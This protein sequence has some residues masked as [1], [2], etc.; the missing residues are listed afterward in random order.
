MNY[1]HNIKVR[2]LNLLNIVSDI[3]QRYAPVVL[4]LSITCTVK[5]EWTFMKSVKF[6]I[7]CFGH[8]LFIV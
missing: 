1:A 5:K 7:M 4:V 6:S 2:F 8:L 3:L